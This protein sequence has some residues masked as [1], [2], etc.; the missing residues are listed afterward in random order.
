MELILASSSPR[1]MK[2]L[3]M[4]G[5]RFVCEAA[6]IE[7]TADSLDTPA[8]MVEQLAL[9]KAETVFSRHP[10]ACVVGADTLVFLDGRPV[11][12][13]GT[14]ADAR[15]ML[16]S[17]SSRSHEVYSGVA[18]L[19][20]IGK[21]VFHARTVVKFFP[22]SDEQIARYVETGDPLDKAGAYGIQ[23]IGALLVEGI[24]GDFYNVMGL[25]VALLARRL[26]EMGIRPE[27]TP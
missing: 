23:G 18:V 17:L 27:V 10:L 26:H 24:E 14:P 8:G 15:M 25:P 7:E 13:P 19:S 11:G 22:L 1:R 3:S 16:K 5:Y 6:N 2:L 12:K 4:L 9:K 20:P 21:T